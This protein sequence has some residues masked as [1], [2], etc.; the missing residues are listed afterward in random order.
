MN[1]E[2]A[3]PTAEEMVDLAD[4]AIKKRLAAGGIQQLSIM[5]KQLVFDGLD[6]LLRVRREFRAEEFDEAG[7]AIFLADLRGL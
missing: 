1:I 2:M 4:D 3:R 6:S 5:G 7:D